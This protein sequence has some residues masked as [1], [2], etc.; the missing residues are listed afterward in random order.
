M[1][2]THAVGEHAR[3]RTQ[4]VDRS[5]GTSLDGYDH[6]KMV[7]ILRCCWQNW[8]NQRSQKWLSVQSYL[9]TAV[10]FL[11]SHDMLLRGE[12]RRTAELAGLFTIE[13][14]NEDPTPCWPMVLI[15]DNWKP[16]LM[17]RLEYAAVRRHCN[18]MLCTMSHLAFYLFRRWNIVSEKVLAF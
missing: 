8:K 2:R 5:A 16:N 11:F 13:F 12:Y 18:T 17:G 10:D 1:L 6:S 14:S 15:M 9:R 4:F 3:K 7:Y